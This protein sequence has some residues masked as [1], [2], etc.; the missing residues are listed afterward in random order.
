MKVLIWI[1]CFFAN[2]LLTTLINGSGVSLGGIP[3]A[4]LFGVTLWLARTLC[5]KWDER[6]ANGASEQNEPDQMQPITNDI[7]EQVRFCRKCGE[8]LID[9]SGFCRKCGTKIVEIHND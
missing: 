5:K 9:H 1:G 8:K 3:T 4:I 2:A 6:K 7:T